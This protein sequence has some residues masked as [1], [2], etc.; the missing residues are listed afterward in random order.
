MI[1]V[2]EVPVVFFAMVLALSLL[3]ERFLEMTKVLFD[4]LDFRMGW[5]RY[6]SRSADN[7]HKKLKNIVGRILKARPEL[8]EKVLKR[9][10]GKTLGKSG[11]YEG[12]IVIVS[13]DMIRVVFTRS[14]M[15]I[16]AIAIGIYLAFIFK[17][18]LLSFVNK[19]Q[20]VANEPIRI[21]IS[22]IAIGLGSGP[23]HKIITTIERAR[24]KQKEKQ[25]KGA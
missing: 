7:L 9:Y 22:G 15:K 23:I 16:I 17:I 5:D 12:S 8:Q 24:K 14:F 11:G 25:L 18:D 3:I 6:W 21:I 1:E 4:Y 2:L 19:T 20:D 13:G 10:R